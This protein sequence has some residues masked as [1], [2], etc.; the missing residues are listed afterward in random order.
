MSYIIYTR[1]AEYYKNRAC[2]VSYCSNI[3]ELKQKYCK[4][5]TLVKAQQYAWTKAHYGE[6]T[7]RRTEPK[8]SLDFDQW[9]LQGI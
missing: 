1:H 2:L 7:I 4:P 8:E 5:L 6:N 3:G 9:F